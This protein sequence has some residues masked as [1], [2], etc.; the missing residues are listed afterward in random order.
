MKV[1]LQD[2]ILLSC[3]EKQELPGSL[4]LGERSWQ[5]VQLW[6]TVVQTVGG[7]KHINALQERSAAESVTAK[8]CLHHH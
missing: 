8:S 1:L 2:S 7:L 6:G 3:K 4:I 5:H